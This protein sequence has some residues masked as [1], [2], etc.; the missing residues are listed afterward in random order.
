MTD[1]EFYE[2]IGSDYDDTVRRIGGEENVHKFLKMF[3]DDPSFERLSKALSANDAEGSFRSAHTMKG[4]TINLG[5]TKLYNAS[6]ELTEALRD[7]P[8]ADGT[9]EMYERVKKEYS[10][11]MDYL[12]TL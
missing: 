5:F 6:A 12:N 11:V 7:A 3:K 2:S 10:A 8:S 9:A 4:V 1:R